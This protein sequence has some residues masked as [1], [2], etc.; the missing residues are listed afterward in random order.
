MKWYC[1]WKLKRVHAKIEALKEVTGSRLIDNYTAHS[2]LRI[3]TRMA[4]VLQNRLDK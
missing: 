4:E 1:K 3:L 2:R